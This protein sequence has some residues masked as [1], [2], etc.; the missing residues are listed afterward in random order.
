MGGAVGLNCPVVKKTT[1]QM[2]S[3]L[4]G[5]KKIYGSSLHSANLFHIGPKQARAKAPCSSICF[6][7]QISS[8]PRHS[9]T[10]DLPRNLHS[11]V[12][13]GSGGAA[14]PAES[15]LGGDHKEEKDLL[16]LL[17]GL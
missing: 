7:S 2:H 12:R 9:A 14:F 6:Q 17:H 4:G 15:R 5:E 13:L 10:L 3:L 11:C 1:N 8:P 16:L